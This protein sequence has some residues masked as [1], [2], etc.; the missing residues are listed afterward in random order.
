MTQRPVGDPDKPSRRVVEQRVRN[1]II[2]YL[3]LASSFEQQQEYEREV[4]IAHIPYEVINQWEDWVHKDPREDRDLPDVYDE[5][6]IEAMRQFHTA[7]D[8]AASAVPNNYPPLSE[9][10]ALPAW[11]RL[12]DAAGSALS[13]FMR[14]GKMPED[15][16]VA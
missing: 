5:A 9:V 11:D 16:E 8:D 1:R 4:P 14:R 10:Q 7:W 2:E 6:E 15:H 3:E 12:R 13:V